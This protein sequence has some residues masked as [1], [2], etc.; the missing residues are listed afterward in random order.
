MAARACGTQFADLLLV[1]KCDLVNE[2][3][4]GAIEAFL[5]KINPAAEIVRTEH[6]VLEPAAL[7]GKA[8]FRMEKAEEH[9]QWLKEA[10]EHEHT[11]ETL[12]C[13]PPTRETRILACACSSCCPLCAVCA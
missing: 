10:R 5:R 7:L 6:S 13:T 9:P 8:R 11:P 12:E 3:Q 2:E 1:N 4:R